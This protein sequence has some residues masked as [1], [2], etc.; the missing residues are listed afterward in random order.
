MVGFEVQL[1][2]LNIY[3]LIL[4]ILG[5]ATGRNIVIPTSDGVILRGWHIPPSNSD[6]IHGLSLQ[7][8]YERDVYLDKILQNSSRI[9]IFLHGNAGTRGTARRVSIVKQFVSF[10]E[11]HVIAIDYRG[12]AD[13]SG[14]PTEIG[15]TEDILAVVSWIRSKLS[16]K[17]RNTTVILYGQSLGTGISLGFLNSHPQMSGPEGIIKA[18]ILDAPFVSLPEAAMSHWLAAPFRIFPIL[19]KLM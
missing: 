9:V 12:F 8:S 6:A 11:S 17:A 16:Q 19:K 3:K 2:L 13:S 15:T 5:L 18:V 14:W 1:N 7:S 10:C 4:L